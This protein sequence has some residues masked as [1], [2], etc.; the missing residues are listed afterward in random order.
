MRAAP[1][2][3]GLRRTYGVV[4]TRI[5]VRDEKWYRKNNVPPTP[6]VKRALI[7]MW[8]A[9]FASRGRVEFQVLT[10]GTG[11]VVRYDCVLQ[12]F[13]EGGAPT[14]LSHLDILPGP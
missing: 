10:T 5:V 7:A 12:G 14:H 11:H 13:R 2:L 8:K 9:G 6:V 3:L 1:P 4:G